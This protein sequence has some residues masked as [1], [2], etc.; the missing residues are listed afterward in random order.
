MYVCMCICYVH[1]LT[2]IHFIHTHT[3]T[4]IYTHSH[5]HTYTYIHLFILV[6]THHR[7]GTH[8]QSGHTPNT[9]GIT[10]VHWNVGTCSAVNVIESD[11]PY[12]I[13]RYGLAFVLLMTYVISLSPGRHTSFAHFMKSNR[14]QWITTKISNMC[15]RYDHNT[16][17][18]HYREAVPRHQWL[19]NDVLNASI[20]GALASITLS[21]VVL[22]FGYYIYVDRVG[23]YKYDPIRYVCVCMCVCMCI[24]MYVCVYV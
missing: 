20:G 6:Y 22:S 23:N 19:C 10:A 8:F 4:Y 12:L 11:F 18:E 14:F 2:S 24:C 1:T 13:L 17:L 16:F 5:T 9:R 7:A 15:R 21:V 3:H